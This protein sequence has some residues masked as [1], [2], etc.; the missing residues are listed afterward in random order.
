[1]NGNGSIFTAL[2]AVAALGAASCDKAR[3]LASGAK[4]WFGDGGKEETDTAGLVSDVS[5]VGKEEGEEI[6]ATEPR[7]VIVEYYSDT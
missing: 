2:V 6:I 7:L 1:M 3:D 4:S 5:S